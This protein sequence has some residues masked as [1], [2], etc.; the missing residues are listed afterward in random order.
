MRGLLTCL[1]EL[2]I[3]NN[4]SPRRKPWVDT[5]NIIAS[6]VSGGTRTREILGV[7][8]LPLMLVKS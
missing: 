5:A 7:P 4:C 8:P 6:R 2:R 3:V 1:R